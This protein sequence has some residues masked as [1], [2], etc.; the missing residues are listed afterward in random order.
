MV[1]C[2][3]T[4]FF[5]IV[6]EHREVN[7]PGEGQLIR[8]N[9]TTAF[10]H[11]D[12][13]CAQRSSNYRRFIGNEEQQVTCFNFS[14]FFDCFD[15]FIAEEFSDGG[16]YAAFC[17]ELQPSHTLSTVDAAE[18]NE[19][20]QLTTRNICI[21]F[22]VNAF[23]LT[24]VSD[25]IVE[26]LEGAAL[27]SFADIFQLH[28]EAQVRFIAAETIHSIVPGQTLERNLDILAQSTLEDVVN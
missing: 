27:N 22:Y 1:H 12:T 3:I 16:F 8:I 21:S 14:S 4:F 20:I 11:F 6:L 9:Q 15:V 5:L 2:N 10:S 25:N 19:L 18:F 23:Y 28:A 24:A 7:Y 26:Y 17:R 13:Q